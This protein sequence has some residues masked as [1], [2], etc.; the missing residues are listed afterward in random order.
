M[1]GWKS[2]NKVKTIF[3]GF[4]WNMRIFPFIFDVHLMCRKKIEMKNQMNY[5]FCVCLFIFNIKVIRL[6]F[7]RAYQFEI[8][9]A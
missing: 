6:I 9:C 7:L 2:Q 8:I 3:E 4:Q 1:N 5:F